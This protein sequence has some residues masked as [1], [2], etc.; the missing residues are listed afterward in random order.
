MYAL[1]TQQPM[2]SNLCNVQVRYSLSSGHDFIDGIHHRLLLIADT[3][4]P[5]WP[6][7]KQ[8]HVYRDIREGELL[9][10]YV[11]TCAC[12]RIKCIVST[13]CD[14]NYSGTLLPS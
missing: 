11:H 10:M 12:G 9:C 8:G 5:R 7:V 2:A 3:D 13:S 1:G 14:K 6:F 4:L